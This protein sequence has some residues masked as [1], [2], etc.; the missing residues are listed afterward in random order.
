MISI[1]QLMFKYILTIFAI[2]I[3]G[4][5]S[6][7]QKS[8]VFFDFES[9]S[10]LDRLHWKC[11]T[12]MNLSDEHA[13]H[14]SKSLKL[15]LYP[16]E[17]PGLA[18]MIRNNNWEG[19]K[20]LGFDIFNPG[21]KEIQIAVR[22]DDREEAPEYKDRYNHSFVLAPGVNR[23]NIPLDALITSGTDRSLDLKKIY[24]LVVFMVNPT[25]KV[26]LYVDYV[27]LES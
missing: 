19:Y 21:E 22:L 27:R 8:L 17:Y 6:P 10:E 26:T 15:E 12:L 5:H 25:E 24:S 18:P 7:I 2:L 1:P 13:T 20:S 4:C 16:S 14:G 11:H 3:M 23:I 9:E